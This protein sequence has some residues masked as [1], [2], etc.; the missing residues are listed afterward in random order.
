MIKTRIARNYDANVSSYFIDARFNIIVKLILI[1][2]KKKKSKKKRYTCNNAIMF[3][4]MTFHFALYNN[5]T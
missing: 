3:K 2:K 5:S 1:K 4:I